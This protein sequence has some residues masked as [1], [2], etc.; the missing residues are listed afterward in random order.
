M[1]FALRFR[2]VFAKT[3]L[4][5]VV[6][7]LLEILS[8]LFRGDIY[9]RYLPV[10]IQATNI[11][12][13]LFYFGLLY[14]GAAIL[15]AVI[16][17]ILPFK[18]EILFPCLFF[19]AFLA[20]T[21]SRLLPRD[22]G[23]SLA[24]IAVFSISLILGSSLFFF[25]KQ[26]NF[27]VGRV[28]TANGLYCF[29]AAYL[30]PHLFQFPVS[31]VIQALVTHV[32]ILS[33]A[34]LLPGKILA[35]LI[36]FS[37]VV[38]FQGKQ[39]LPHFASP[40]PLT[41]FN[42]VILVGIDG[43]SPDV[44]FEMARQGKMPAVRKIMEQ[45]IYGRLHTLSVPFSPLVWNTIY[46]GTEPRQHGIMAFTFTGVAGGNPF[47]SL[48]LDNWTNS[49]WM[50][51]ATGLLKNTRTISTLIPSLSK[52]RLRPALWDITNQNNEAAVV[53]GGWTTYPPEKINGLFVSDYAFSKKSD[54]LGSYF[55]ENERLEE[56]LTFHPDVSSWPS[57]LQRY[58][59]KDEK[60]HFLWKGIKNTFAANARFISTYYY[61]TDAF[62]HHYGT[63]IGRK[64]TAEAKRKQYSDLEEKIYT[65]I[66]RFIKDY[67]NQMDD[68]T[69][70]IICSDHGFNNDKRQHN[71]PV[72]GTL[73]L[74]GKN[75]R[76]ATTLEASV[77]N[78]A[79]T[80]T[81]A[82]GFAPDKA[83][84]ETPLRQAFEGIIPE[85][86]PKDYK[87]NR[88]FFEVREKGFE[89]EKLEELRDLQYINR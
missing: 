47:L 46:T 60:T 73:L 2:I 27:T 34:L 19:V 64:A 89:L 9:P 38:L 68:R 59:S 88:D 82:L 86:A 3:L 24:R 72:D 61:S 8:Y 55:P 31:N 17:T 83:F 18:V 32:V 20:L 85:I 70:L 48:W 67:L 54:F 51:R 43:L 7:L 30:L 35:G 5:L 87:T 40:V 77:Y 62:G 74:F 13:I 65:N 4:F 25:L 26:R 75:V 50:H 53:L 16:F 56:L 6:P 15:A 36:V 52:N 23:F 81:Y 29:A 66:D 33:L 58:I 44:T 57:D 79:P 42:R 28:F 45:G 21:M 10:S 69:L 76:K 84:R 37:V 11:L 39:S 63:Y 80:I 41:A 1:N 12:L 78:I 22:S 49:D 71:Y 14:L